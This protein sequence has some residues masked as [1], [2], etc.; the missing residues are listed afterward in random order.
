MVERN[1]IILLVL[2]ILTGC[3]GAD[4]N[5][6]SIL[7]ARFFSNRCTVEQ[8]VKTEVTIV[9]RIPTTTSY[10][11]FVNDVLVPDVNDVFLIP[12]HFNKNDLI[13]CLISAKDT[14]G[15]ESTPFL[16]G[17]IVISNTPPCI[18][19]ADFAVID[20][21]R[22]GVDLSVEAQ[23][24]DLDNDEVIIRYKWY[25]DNE[26]VSNEPVLSGQLLETG[27]NV[28]VELV[29]FDGDTVGDR[30]EITRP[31]VVQNN[32]PKIIGT[33]TP[34]IE[35]TT[36]TCKINMEDQD[37]DKLS[38]SIQK[39]PSGMTIDNTGN[40][41]WFFPQ[42]ITDTTFNIVVKVTDSRGAGEEIRIPLKIKR[43]NPTQ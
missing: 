31:V 14:L 8:S 5:A 6:P 18:K 38:Y 3:K 10:Q 26:L 27:R 36:V 29:P 15:Q 7:K 23:S 11:W 35:D 42:S 40:I 9:S 13:T 20:S 33:P 12:E 21:I 39:G 22:K 17:P 32:P 19:W 1:T 34:I 24:E 2:L 28:R 16:L 4:S 25:V 30:F 41:K 43:R 37:G